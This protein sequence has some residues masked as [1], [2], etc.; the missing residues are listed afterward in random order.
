MIACGNKENLEPPQGPTAGK[1]L[2]E[3]DLTAEQLEAARHHFIQN[4]TKTLVISGF[5]GHHLHHLDVEFF[6]LDGVMVPK[7]PIF[8][9]YMEPGGRITFA[10]KLS[11]EFWFNIPEKIKNEIKKREIRTLEL[12][13]VVQE[14][15]FIGEVARI[16]THFWSAPLGPHIPGT[17]LAGEVKVGLYDFEYNTDGDLITNELRKVDWSI[18]PG[19]HHTL[20]SPENASVNMDI[21]KSNNSGWTLVIDE[22]NSRAAVTLHGIYSNEPIGY[23][24]HDRFVDILA[25]NHTLNDIMTAMD[26]DL[27]FNGFLSRLKLLAH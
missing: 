2:F 23:S 22:N 10:A 3:T 27:L 26:V 14:Y 18:H 19:L 15:S 21:A 25:V 17:N 20:Y 9:A 24:P 5:A 11:K 8:G 4:R 16:R 6:E 1:L 12:F 7:T 13:V